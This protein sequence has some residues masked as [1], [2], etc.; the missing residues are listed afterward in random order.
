MMRDRDN[1][2]TEISD[3]LGESFDLQRATEKNR[4]FSISLGW[5]KY[6]TK[7]NKLLGLAN[8][9]P[10]EDSFARA[11]YDWQHTNRIK[12][13]GIIGPN[14]WLKIKMFLGSLGYPTSSSSSDISNSSIVSGSEI[15][16][17]KGFSPEDLS[18]EKTPEMTE[19]KRLVYKITFT[20]SCC[21]KDKASGKWIIK[22]P[23]VLR[24]PDGA[25]SHTTGN[26][27]TRLIE[28]AA[29]WCVRLLN[30]ARKQIEREGKSGNITIDA[31]SGYRDA[32]KQFSLWNKRF[33]KYYYRAV[34]GKEIIPGLYDLKNAHALSYHIGSAT[35]T[36]GFSDHNRGL[37]MDFVTTQNG[38]K[39]THDKIEPN[40]GLWKRSWFYNWLE[41]NAAIYRFYPRPSINEPWHWVYRPESSV[42]REISLPTSCGDLVGR[43]Y[44]LKNIDLTGDKTIPEKKRYIDNH[45]LTGIYVP[46][47]FT[48]ASKA[49]IVIYLH[50]YKKGYPDQNATIREY[51]NKNLFP[52]F[53]LREGLLKIRKNAILIAPTLGSKSQ[54]GRLVDAKNGGLDWYLGL[55]LE[56]LR[57]KGITKEIG[58]VVLASHSGG[59]SPMLNLAINSTNKFII[60]EC[61]GF[62]CLYSGYADKDKRN[63]LYT[64]PERW[65]NWAKKNPDKKLFIYYYESTRIEAEYLQTKINNKNKQKV[66]NI[67]L[68]KLDIRYAKEK[69]KDKMLDK[70]YDKYQR[71][72]HYWVPITYWEDRISGLKWT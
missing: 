4:Q 19:F 14:S 60:K 20:R 51:W 38:K 11:V 31:G 45:R 41:K 66:D 7:I 72:P 55:V 22:T 42:S 67:L 40:I 52:L 69:T 15:K 63:K 9:S 17:P 25:L 24:M 65:L 57:N 8:V 50:G 53:A 1:F 26:I 32:S 49:N 29:Q 58:E 30:A 46:S 68:T 56:F 33:S 3:L 27:D 37:A 10:S 2:E 61:W 64:Q 47:F 35:A 5:N 13:D 62:D 48:C 12:P 36:P 23:F 21:K 54:S 6:L 43:T 18:P 28:E 71:A 34:K 39:Y 59:G 70:K 44:Y 16:L